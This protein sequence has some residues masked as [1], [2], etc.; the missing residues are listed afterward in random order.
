MDI[1]ICQR[2]VHITADDQPL[3]RIVNL[4]NIVLHLPHEL[5]LGRIV[6][7]SIRDIGHVE[8]NPIE[9]LRLARPDSIDVPCGDVERFF[10]C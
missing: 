4:P 6:L 10:R 8:R 9:E 2:H 5:Q 1:G 7:S 3:P